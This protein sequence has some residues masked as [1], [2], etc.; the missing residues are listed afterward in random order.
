MPNIHSV[1]NRLMHI[2]HTFTYRH[3]G[4]ALAMVVAVIM[5]AASVQ[6]GDT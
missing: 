3:G 1:N 4:A 5:A 2:K 6:I